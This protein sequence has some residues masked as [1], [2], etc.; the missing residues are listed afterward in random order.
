MSIQRHAIDFAELDDGRR[1]RLA[2]LETTLLSDAMGGRNTMAAAIKPL[3]P[4]SRLIGQ[5]RTAFSP[6]AVRAAIIAIAVARP[7]DVLVIDGGGGDVHATLGGIM[8]RDALRQGVAGCVIDGLVR[9]SAEV[10]ELGLTVFCRGAIPHGAGVDPRGEVD[11]PV[12]AGGVRVRPGDVIIGDDDG[13]VVV[14]LAEVD[15]VLA[16]AEA[17]RDAEAGWM[18]GIGAGRSLAEIHGFDIPPAQ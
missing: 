7:G 15:T 18:S 16:R 1:A 2:A 13:V 14:P 4:G 9:D 12:R 5:A 8:A 17:K 3:A 10:R 11:A 6:G